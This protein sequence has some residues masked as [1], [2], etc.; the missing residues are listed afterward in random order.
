M[1]E[2]KTFRE[3]IEEIKELLKTKSE[4]KFRLPLRIKLL[5]QRL[6]KNYVIV[7]IIKTNGAVKIKMLKIEDDTIKI[8]DNF[9]DA[10]ASSILR[11][12]KYPLLLVPEW[13][14]KPIS[15]ETNKIGIEPWTPKEDFEKAEK[16]GTL[17]AAQKL[18][19]TKM[20]MEAFKP[21]TKI[22]GK[23]IVIGLVVL[24]IGYFLLDY[25]KIL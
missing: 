21:T 20:K 7:M 4:K 23:M 11:Y 6:R 15:P 12:G 25:L 14:M 5:T 1:E 24:V 16:N 13:N 10:S 2:E 22:S 9:Y 8:G 18:I 3:D 19:L 17:T